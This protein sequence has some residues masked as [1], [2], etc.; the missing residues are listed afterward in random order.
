MAYWRDHPR[1]AWAEIHRRNAEWWATHDEWGRPL[2]RA[3]IRVTD[4][5]RVRDWL[6]AHRVTSYRVGDQTRLAEHLGV[7]ASAVSYVM[8]QLGI[9][10]EG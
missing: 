3:T 7:S 9:R 2:P 8:A 6:T 10:E 1:E 4:R 5:D